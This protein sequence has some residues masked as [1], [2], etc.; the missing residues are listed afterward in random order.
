MVGIE[1][2]LGYKFSDSEL[3]EN[4]L[5][6]RSYVYHAT[7]SPDN[8]R[9]EFLGDSVISLIVCDFLYE[10]F[11]S[12]REDRLSKLKSTIV[13][14]KN[15]ASWANDISLGKYIKLSDSERDSGGGG[16]SSILAGCFEAVIGAIFLDGGFHSA[17]K[18]VL[19]FLD[20]IQWEELE[21]DSKSM[22][23]EIIQSM[24]NTLPVYNIIKEEGPAH[25]KIFE[26]EVIVKKKTYG[27][28]VG[29][30]KKEAQKNA[31]EDAIKNIKR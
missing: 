2:V 28:G 6:H 30:S 27:R 12:V 24:F 7:A 19:K 22:L 13:S 20:K 18:V 15:L 10:K 16:K 9:L 11:T 29:K 23:Q 5:T 26:V 25:N 4:S 21:A 14:Q 8:E 3:L 31:A 1:Q 17:K